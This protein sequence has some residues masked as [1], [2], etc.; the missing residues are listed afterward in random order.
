M[1]KDVTS[2]TLPTPSKDWMLR[3]LRPGPE[4]TSRQNFYAPDEVNNA[5]KG[6]MCNRLAIS[7]V[8]AAMMEFPSSWQAT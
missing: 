3:Q 7:M 2:K 6:Q 8:I 4:L 1:L 5:V